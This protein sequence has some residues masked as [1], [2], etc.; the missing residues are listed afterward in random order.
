MAATRAAGPRRV[1]NY[2][3]GLRGSDHEISVTKLKNAALI[4]DASRA[5][6]ILYMDSQRADEPVDGPEQALWQIDSEELLQALQDAVRTKQATTLLPVLDAF[7][8]RYAPSMLPITPPCMA[9]EPSL[10]G[11]LA[12][13]LMKQYAKL[14]PVLAHSCWL[15]SRAS[16]NSR[17]EL[18]QAGA[19][20]AILG[21]LHSSYSSDLEEGHRWGM[22][23]R[24]CG[25]AQVMSQ[26]LEALRNLCDP[27]NDEPYG[28]VIKAAANSLKEIIDAMDRATGYVCLP[29]LRHA[30][31]LIVDL[32]RVSGST[33][34]VCASKHRA[35]YWIVVGGKLEQVLTRWPQAMDEDWKELLRK[36]EVLRDLLKRLNQIEMR[37]KQEQ[38]A[39]ALAEAEAK[40]NE[41]FLALLAE[42]EEE[43]HASKADGSAASRKSKKKKKKKG[44]AEPSPIASSDSQA[45]TEAASSEHTTVEVA[46]AQLQ[47]F[48]E[49]A[50]QPPPHGE[51]VL[52]LPPP[53]EEQAE[54]PMPL[55]EAAVAPPPLPTPPL[56]TPPLPTPPLPTQVSLA[57]VSLDTGRAEVPESTIGGQTTCVVC[58]SNPKSHLAVP[59]GH[60]CACGPC[61]EKMRLCPYCRAPAT[62][63]V[64]ARIV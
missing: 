64:Q 46:L 4:A 52:E 53:S 33:R 49:R 44:R 54:V 2:E 18:V 62:L 55:E 57:D 47:P 13:K 19:I 56:P 39:K 7:Y 61:S 22:D 31:W 6:D 26:G 12:L 29:G 58:F 24:Q 40:S 14:P 51:P 8:G 38:M 10:F 50:E 34:L 5:S 59:C 27:L 1:M 41:M 48:E 21:A 15:L 60:Q 16:L 30:A 11:F 35:L 20:D 25:P 36:W 37:V 9:R 42:E 63:W 32:C 23:K 45:T 17:E 28:G 3:R 43:K